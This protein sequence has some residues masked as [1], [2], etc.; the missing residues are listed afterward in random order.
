MIKRRMTWRDYKD[1]IAEIQETER[2]KRASTRIKNKGLAPFRRPL[3]ENGE[4]LKGQAY[5]DWQVAVG[6]IKG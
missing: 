5:K 6:L 1:L 3:D 4:K 2:R